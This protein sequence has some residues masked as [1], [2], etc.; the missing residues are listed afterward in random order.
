M[1]KLYCTHHIL[2]TT[3]KICYY[4]NLSM[5]LRMNTRTYLTFPGRKI[6]VCWTM[7]LMSN[8]LLWLKLHTPTSA[9]G[10]LRFSNFVQTILLK[11]CVPHFS[12]IIVSSFFFFL[13]VYKL[14]SYTN[15]HHC[16]NAF[17][18]KLMLYSLRL[19]VN[20]FSFAII[21]SFAYQMAP[22]KKQEKRIRLYRN[23]P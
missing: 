12:C 3:G 14:G 11:C 10:I 20:F 13:F 21:S 19:P 23:Q 15:E 22:L 8:V 1:T 2:Y 16:V 5:W 17:N 7:E 6:V 4:Q 9:V 18:I